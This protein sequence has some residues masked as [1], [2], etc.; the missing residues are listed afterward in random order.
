MCSMVAAVR[1]SNH[2]HDEVVVDNLE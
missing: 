1:H 2:G